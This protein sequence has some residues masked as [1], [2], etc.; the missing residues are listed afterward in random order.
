MTPDANVFIPDDN[1]FFYV[2][3]LACF[4][5]K[6]CQSFAKTVL[7]VFLLF[8]MY[9]VSRIFLLRTFSPVSMSML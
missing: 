6:T 9:L 1:S 4:K 8:Q 7:F 3:V 5:F 2:Y